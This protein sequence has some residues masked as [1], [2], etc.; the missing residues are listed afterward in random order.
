[1]SAPLRIRRP[2]KGVRKVARGGEEDFKFYLDRLVK[3]IPGPAVGLYLI[4]NG[5]IPKEQAI[6][7]V[8]VQI[9][10]SILCL[11]AVIVIT[12]FGTTDPQ[13]KESPDWKHVGISS[14]SFVIWLYTIG[15]PFAAFNPVV[16]Y[17]PY[18]GSLLVLAWTFFVPFF[19]K[20]PPE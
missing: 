11:F 1:V 18:I 10:W 20:G 14:V 8:I 5:L 16:P 3:L 19:Y 2:D 4:G 13:K 9:L 12:A 6:L 7:P 15:G 17:V